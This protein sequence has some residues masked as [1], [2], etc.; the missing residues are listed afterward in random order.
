MHEVCSI[1]L[2]LDEYR[3]FQMKRKEARFFCP[4]DG[5]NNIDI[6]C[7]DNDLLSQYVEHLQIRHGFS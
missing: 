6:E 7:I 1:F 4:I 5:T 3:Y 2:F